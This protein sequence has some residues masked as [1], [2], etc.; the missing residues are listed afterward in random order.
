M[1]RL[2][3]RLSA[4]V[5]VL[6]VGAFAVVQAQRTISRAEAR[7]QNAS[8]ES[9]AATKSSAKSKSKNALRSDAQAAGAG[10]PQAD[11]DPFGSQPAN[12]RYADRYPTN[13]VAEI[14]AGGQL[15]E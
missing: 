15:I 9:P 8:A 2:L 7:E 14:E 6:A 11:K 5:G 1:M 10:K 12:D 3:I 4:L 13:N